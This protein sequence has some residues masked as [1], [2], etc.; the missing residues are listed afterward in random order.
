MMTQRAVPL[1]EDFHELHF[2]GGG[3]PLPHTGPH[4]E[5]SVWSG[6]KSRSERK[7]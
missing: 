3:V 6:D 4:D 7:A 5:A 1:R 2:P